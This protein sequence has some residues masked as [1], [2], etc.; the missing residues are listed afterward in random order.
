MHARTSSIPKPETVFVETLM[1]A[2]ASYAV[3]FQLVVNRLHVDTQLPR[4]FRLILPGMLESLENQFT[5][6]VGDSGRADWEYELFGTQ[7]R[8]ADVWRKIFLL[9]PLAF[10]ED[11]RT[12]DNIPEF[13]DVA[14]P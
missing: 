9:D 2:Y 5:F 13:S 8:I 1:N 10:G 4:G 14:G 11:N 3:R 7:H 6:G 12:L